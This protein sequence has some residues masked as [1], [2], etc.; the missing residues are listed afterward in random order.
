MLKQC[1]KTTGEKTP[2]AKAPVGFLGRPGFANSARA[3]PGAGNMAAI[4]KR[5]LAVPSAGGQKS[6]V[7][8]ANESASTIMANET[9]SFR[10][11][12]RNCYTRAILRRMSH[13]LQ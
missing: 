10:Q 13:R 1:V 4:V 7:L 2:G 11:I 9:P 8:E 6:L 3:T 5:I 12:R